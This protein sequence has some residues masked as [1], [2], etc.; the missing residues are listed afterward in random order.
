MGPKEAVM[1]AEAFNAWLDHMQLS[2]RAA[3][4]VLG[5]TRQTIHNYRERGAP[6]Y[7]GLA[8]AAIAAGLEPWRVPGDAAGIG[9]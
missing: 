5:I 9:A 1:S 7:V 8:C 6:L 3:V 2:E 4:E